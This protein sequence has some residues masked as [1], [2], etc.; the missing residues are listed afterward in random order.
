M[1]LKEGINRKPLI[2]SSH[3]SITPRNT[4]PEGM[5]GGVK[6]QRMAT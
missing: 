2:E 6:S 5:D 3:K 1:S 4:I